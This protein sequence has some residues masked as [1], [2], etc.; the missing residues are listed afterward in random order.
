[1]AVFDFGARV[2]VMD[3]DEQFAFNVAADA[4]TFYELGIQASALS[5]TRVDAMGSDTDGDIDDLKVL[6]TS[7]ELSGKFVTLLDVSPED[8]ISPNNFLFDQSSFVIFGDN[9]ASDLDGDTDAGGNSINGTNDGDYLSGLGGNDTINGLDGNDNLLG[10]SGNDRL[11]GG[12]GADVLNGGAGTDNIQGAGGNDVMIW[13]AGDSFNGGV[14]IDTLKIASGN[15]DLTTAANP[16]SRLVSIE[17]IDLRSGAHTLKLNQS[18]VLDM[19]PTGQANQI[20]ILGDGSDTVNIAGG[21]VMGGAAPAG[22]TRYTIGSAV[23]LID[24]DITVL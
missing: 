13:G 9:D 3:G 23:L 4:V 17:Q 1:M 16:N 10:D 8:L 11:N 19:T 22:F 21:Q 15:V 12:G 24:S 5:F 18:D 7:G 6:V 14:N 2:A 20:K